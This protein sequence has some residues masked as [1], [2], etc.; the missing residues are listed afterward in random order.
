MELCYPMTRDKL[1]KK[2]SPP[3]KQNYILKGQK[4]D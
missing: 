3:K 1:S 4:Y 2:P